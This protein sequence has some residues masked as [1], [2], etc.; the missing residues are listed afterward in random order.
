[1]LPEAA[2]SLRHV[3]TAAGDLP[4]YDLD[5]STLESP[6]D[7]GVEAASLGG[8][9][10]GTP[11]IEGAPGYEATLALLSESAYAGSLMLRLAF[12]DST[13]TAREFIAQIQGMPILPGWSRFD[14]TTAAWQAFD[15]AIDKGNLAMVF[16]TSGSNALLNLPMVAI[17]QEDTIRGSMA[18]DFYET[19]AEQDHVTGRGGADTIRGGAGDDY[20]R[21]G[22]GPDRLFGEG[23]GDFLW[24]EGGNDLLS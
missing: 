1:M 7:M 23:D 4:R 22:I 21:G 8:G 19:G 5:W 18:A 20:L 16:P 24:G 9:H 10:V 11:V 3:Q 12:A 14:G 13:G 2:Q 6:D 17:T 15:T